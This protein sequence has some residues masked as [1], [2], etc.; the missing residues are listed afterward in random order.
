M[1]IEIESRPG[2]SRNKG[3]TSLAEVWIEI[4]VY[5]LMLQEIEVTSLAEVWIEMEKSCVDNL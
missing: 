3:V 1:W 2:N 5:G 4:H